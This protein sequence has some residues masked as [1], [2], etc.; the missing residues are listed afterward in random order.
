[1]EYIM[2]LD[3]IG[4]DDECAEIQDLDRLIEE[5]KKMDDLRKQILF[6]HASHFEF[7][8]NCKKLSKMGLVEIKKGDPVYVKK[9]NA[10]SK[11]L[12]KTF[13]SEWEDSLKL[14]WQC[15]EDKNNV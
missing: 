5:L 4:E 2:L 9:V 11:L 1:M 13:P 14:Y 10:F 8:R 7:N 6:N 15:L 3:G 12:K